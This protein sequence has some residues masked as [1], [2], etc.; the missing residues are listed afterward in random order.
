MAQYKGLDGGPLQKVTARHLPF[1]LLPDSDN[2]GDALWR[3]RKQ[4]QD[5]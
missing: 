4:P 2:E 5:T 3:D 1:R